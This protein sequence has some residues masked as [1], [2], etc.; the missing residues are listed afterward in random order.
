MWR[1]GFQPIKL[2]TYY[3]S[4]QVRVGVQVDAAALQGME[5]D[6]LMNQT[7][8]FLLLHVNTAAMT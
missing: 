5:P 2:H 3:G 7:C 1:D 6:D 8:F 4:L